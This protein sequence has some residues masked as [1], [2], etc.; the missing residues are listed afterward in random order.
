MLS[1][2]PVTP[3]AA[4]EKHRIWSLYL[5]SLTL[6]EKIKIWEGPLDQYPTSAELSKI[7]PVDILP[8]QL[9][10]IAI[11]VIKFAPAQVICGLLQTLSCVYRR[12]TKEN[13][14]D[15]DILVIFYFL[16]PS[17]VSQGI[18][19]PFYQH[20]SDQKKSVC[21]AVFKKGDIV[22][23]CRQCGKDTTCVQCDPCFRK[24]DHSG[25]EVYF[26]RASGDSSGCCDCGDA[27][28]W[29]DIPINIYF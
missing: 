26:H 25:H 21:G 28:A 23:T 14:I 6:H 2:P 29:G 16:V 5:I 27:E 7:L 24:S 12:S 11:D 22:W 18:Q 13:I 1:R 3:A 17:F 8:E 15:V 10:A 20:N 19:I 4:E 9:M